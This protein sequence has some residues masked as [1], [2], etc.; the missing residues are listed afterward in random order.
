MCGTEQGTYISR[1]GRRVESFPWNKCLPISRGKARLE[2]FYALPQKDLVRSEEALI[3]C[4]LW[5][6]GRG[7]G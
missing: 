1:V 5:T 2:P 3:V 4:V 6:T 7:L